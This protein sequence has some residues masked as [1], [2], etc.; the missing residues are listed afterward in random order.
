MNILAYG[1]MTLEGDM[2]VTPYFEAMYNTLEVNQNSGE[3]QL[4]PDACS[5]SL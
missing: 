2:N 1:E 3:G 4:F 5:K